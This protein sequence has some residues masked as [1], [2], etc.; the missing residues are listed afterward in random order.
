MTEVRVATADDVPRMA[1]SLS[2]AFVDDPLARYMMGGDDLDFD[3]GVAF[4]STMSKIELPHELVYVSPG[5]EAVALWA[6]P[7]KWK[8]PPVEMLKA[9]P[10]LLRLFGRRAVLALQ[11]MNMLERKHPHEPHYYLAVLGTDPAHQRKGFGAAVMEPVL[12]RCDT[13]GLGAYLESSKAENVPYYRRH[14]FEVRE[15]VVHKHDGPRQW[16]M[17]RDPR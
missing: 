6:P 5:C 9:A 17:W 16:L 8:L 15:E 3:K 13:E 4:F 11:G 1:A 7:G 14:G 12:A 2:R 10:T